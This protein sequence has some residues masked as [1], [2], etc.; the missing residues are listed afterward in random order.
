[1]ALFCA[2]YIPDQTLKE[3][4]FVSLLTKV[5]AKLTRARAHTQDQ[6]DIDICF[7]LPFGAE[8]PDFRGMRFHSWQQRQST[9]KI[10]AA[11]PEHM[12]NSRHTESYII[13]A[14][15]D[16]VDNAADFFGEIKLPFNSQAFHSQ[17]QATRA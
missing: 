10:E 3:C 8:R 1:M 16:A 17:I 4:Q 6:P 13:A 5:A 7:L 11:V 12:L 14:I 9:L 15:E 2:A